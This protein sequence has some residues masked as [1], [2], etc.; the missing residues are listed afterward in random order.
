MYNFLMLNPLVHQMSG[1]F[2]I[3]NTNQL[4]FVLEAQC[5]LCEIC[6]AFVNII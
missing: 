5:S 1:G 2:K 6:T 3:F 4:V